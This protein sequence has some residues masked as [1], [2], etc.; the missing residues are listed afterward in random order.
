MVR[1]SIEIM[2]EIRLAAED[3]SEM[4]T[5][6]T[7]EMYE[8]CMYIQKKS[9]KIVEAKLNAIESGMLGPGGAESMQTVDN[10]LN[11]IDVINAKLQ[12]FKQKYDELK[13]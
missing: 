8:T 11:L 6:M 4:R 3:V 5:E 13:E 2:D 1:Q 12:A 7:F 9:Q 10:Y